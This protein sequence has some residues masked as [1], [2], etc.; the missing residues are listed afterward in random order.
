MSWPAEPSRTYYFNEGQQ[1]NAGRVDKVIYISQTVRE[2]VRAQALPPEQVDYL[3][4]VYVRSPAGVGAIMA[5]HQRHAVA[6][7]GPPGCGRRITAVH[8]ISELDAVPHP[9]YLD[10]SD[11]RRDLPADTGCGYIVDIDEQTVRDMPGLTDMIASYRELLAEADAYLVVTVTS[12]AWLALGS[13][14][15]M[16]AIPVQPPRSTAIFSSHLNHRHADEAGR[17][18]NHQGVLAVLSN[19]VPGDAVRLAELAGASLASADGEEAIEQALD[20][21]RNWTVQLAA[22]FKENEAGYPRA[23]LIAAAALNKAEASTVFEAAERLSQVAKLLRPPGGGLVG[24]GVK[25]LLVQVGANL[26]DD[27]RIRLPRPAYPESIL[28]HV[29]VDRPHLRADLKRWLV[30]LPGG[31]RTPSAEF[32]GFALI[33]LAIRQAD[34]TLITYAVG[35]WAEQSACRALALSALTE[36][37]VSDSIGRTVRRTMYDWAAAK[38][39]TESLKLTVADVC[40][41]PYGKS[42]PRNAMTRLRHLSLNG[43]LKVH[44]RVVSSLLALAGEPALRDFMLREIVSWAKEDGQVSVPGIR[45]FLALGAA[46]GGDFLPGT[47]SDQGKIESLA[48][49]L[50]AALYHPDYT[51]QARE[52]CC[53]WLESAALGMQSPD[54]VTD[55]LARTCEN[56]SDIGT[57]ASLAWRWGHA[58]GQPTTTD[59]EKVCAELLQKAA[60]RD[61]LAPGVSATVLYQAVQED[62][63]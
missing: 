53:G 34:S 15:G 40:G 57:L 30:E 58:G 26:T 55:V 23:L 38:T 22:W 29:W 24:N 2:R 41:G 4:E 18:I 33:D 48:T 56:S 5:L 45:A 36:A 43:D 50:R 46:G 49:G 7:V 20:A 8:A 13:K 42:F 31:L 32:A 39:T 6:L 47:L 59:R 14:T 25:E 17:W 21:Y 27:G 60:D 35:V 12:T 1:I 3:R 10:P 37:S 61:P 62:G 44:E 9:I 63:R 52:M 11:T 16:E 51:N 28:D 19:A 54:V